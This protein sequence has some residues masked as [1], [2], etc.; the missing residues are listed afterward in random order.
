MTR[1]LA[2]LIALLLSFALLAGCGGDSEKAD[3]DGADSSSTSVDEA[4]ATLV[5][6]GIAQVTAGEDAA[7]RTTFENVL[8]LDAD[9]AY[10]HYNLGQLAQKSGR[11]REAMTSYDAALA[12]DPEMAPALFNKA[13]LTEPADLDAAVELYRRALDSDPDLAPAH[14]RLGFAL[15]H[16]GEKSEAEEHLAS[17]IRLDPSMADV[18]APSYD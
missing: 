1:P 10:A 5:E 13:I 9:N 15:L 6:T 4:T 17:G 14:M 7:A 11:D 12:A 16:L 2:A 8:A 18:E 3:S